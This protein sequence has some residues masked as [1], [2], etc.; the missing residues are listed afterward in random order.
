MPHHR[1][2]LHVSETTDVAELAPLQRAYYY[3]RLGEDAAREAEAAPDDT[4]RSAYEFLAEHWLKLA[5][6][7]EEAAG[8]KDATMPGWEL[9]DR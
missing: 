5:L 6:A 4:M 9:P 3:R 2:G 7:T 8:M 1:L